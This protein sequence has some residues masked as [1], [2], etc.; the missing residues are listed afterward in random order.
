MNRFQRAIG[1]FDAHMVAAS[2]T[3]EAPPTISI[4]R[5]LQLIQAIP[6]AERYKK[7]SNGDEIFYIRD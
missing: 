4:G 7:Y 1:F 5:A 6:E 3:F 2:N